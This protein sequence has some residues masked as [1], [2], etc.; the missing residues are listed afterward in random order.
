MTNGKRARGLSIMLAAA[1]GVLLTGCALP[2]LPWSQ[3]ANTPAPLPDA[4]QVAQIALAETGA[5]EHMLDPIMSQYFDPG[6]AQ[7]LSLLYSGLFTLDA[8]MV[9]VPALAT[10]YDVTGDGLRYTFH[11][12]S[13]ARFAEGAPLTSADAA[14][15]LSRAM[16]D[17]SSY[18]MGFFTDV[19]DAPALIQQVCQANQRNPRPATLIGDSLLTPDPSTLIIVL[20]R[21]DAALTAMLAEPYSLI[22]ERSFVMRY[23]NQWTQHLADGGGQ[24]TSGMYA[25]TAWRQWGQ[26]GE[27]ALTLDRARGYWG[28]HPLL[29]QVDVALRTL[30]RTQ[31]YLPYR[32]IAAAPSDEIVFDA[33]PPAS[34]AARSAGL[35]YHTAPAR[36]MR[37]LL[38]DTHTA[39]LDDARVRQALALA[40]D[41]TALARLINGL[42][43]NHLI[44]PNTGVYP[45]TLSGDRATAPLTGDVTRARALWQSY[46]QSRC[47]GVASRCPKVLIYQTDLPTFEQA[48]ADRWQSVLPGI[49]VQL[50]SYPDLLMP[51]E[52]PPFSISDA[53]WYEDYPDPRD[54]LLTLVSAPGFSAYTVA[55]YLHDTQ[56]DAL[57]ARAEANLDPGTRLALYQ[58]AENALINDAAVIPIAQ[59][60]ATWA[61][62]PNVASFPASLAPWIP[63]AVWARI[64]LMNGLM[65]ASG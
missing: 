6:T 24:G 52:P 49:N 4:R 48:L 40:L 32:S 63:P 53:S 51:V 20:S 54:W 3:Q 15:S 13:D 62:K 60:Q 9:P 58:Q 21:P 61:L 50:T 57:V 35:T 11:L 14:F 56:A 5:P 17:C 2:A 64:E 23:G 10:S 22:V 8:R 30:T 7:V 16:T 25:L 46:V 1:L 37:Y 44:P 36:F 45:A 33:T 55:P 27:G 59:E 43:T 42:P 41:K 34:G 26:G 18:V 39:P 31:A 12:R 19:K 38:L 65:S 47:G 29:R 28:P